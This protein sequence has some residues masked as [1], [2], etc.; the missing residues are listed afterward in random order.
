MGRQI[1]RRLILAAAVALTALP[2]SAQKDTEQK[3]SLVRLMKGS[4]I[5]LIE[6]YG[7]KYRKAIDATFLHNNTYLICDTALWNVDSK[8]IN[9]WGNVKLMQEETVLTSD[10]LDYD[11][12]E[13][14]AKFRG[15]VVQLQNKQ[16]NI[17]RTNNLDYNTKDSVAFFRDGASMKDK[18]GQVIESVVG[19]YD[20]KTRMFEFRD[21]VNMYTD[22]VFIRS[23]RL[24]Y[25]GNTNKVD[26]FSPVDFWK[27][28]NMLSA[29]RGWYDRNEDI[30]F[31]RDNVHGMSKDQETWSDTLFV[32]KKLRDIKM[33]GHVEIHDTTRSVSGVSNYLYYSDSLSR[34]TMRRD[35]A[36]TM[37]T[38]DKAKNR[39]DTLYAGADTLV[40]YSRMKFQIPEEVFKDARTRLDDMQ[41]DPVSEYRKKAA[42]AA[43]KAK[44]DAEAKEAENNPASR[45]L[46]NAAKTA[47]STARTSAPEES[48]ASAPEESTASAPEEPAVTAA[49]A[50]T[51]KSPSD[52]LRTGSD[53]LRAGRDSLLAG[54]DTLRAGRDSLL[55]GSDSLRTGADTLQVPDSSK[56]N[57]MLGVGNVRI[58]RRDMQIVCDS[59]VF[60]ELDSIARFY[61]DPIV[62]NE[63]NRQYTSDSLFVLI[64]GNAID[65]ASLM[66]NAFII[67]RED[68][69]RFDQIRSTEVM[70]YFDTTSALRRFDAMGGASALFYL[71]ENE[72]LSTVNKVE[73]KMLSAILKDGTIDKVYY[74]DAP[75]NDA[76]PVAQMKDN[77]H[78]MKGFEWRD[79]LRPKGPEDITT[80][81][82]RPSERS[83]Y[84]AHPKAAFKFTDK[85]FPGYM[86]SVYRAIEQSRLRKEMKREPAGDMTEMEVADSAAL[87][88]PDVT[89]SLQTETL[90]QKAV[91]DSLSARADSIARSDSLD[92]AAAEI[93]G[94]AASDVAP[95]R[96]EL[97]EEARKL[98]IARRDARWAELDARDAAKA[99]AKEQKKLEKQRARTKKALLR[100]MK[101][102]AKD[103]AK[104]RKY[105]ERYTRKK[106]REEERAAARQKKEAK[107]DTTNEQQQ[108]EPS[109]ERTPEATSWGDIPAPVESEQQTP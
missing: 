90:K 12:D 98:A 4:S 16:N 82:V 6:K 89:D 46:A 79:Q 72:T 17:L 3:D 22:S 24:V 80:L 108:S 64:R 55:A 42:E 60:S 20:S 69:L 47:E 43:A 8:L 85:Y 93:S 18:D 100:Q 54:S 38:E 77:E 33:L 50:D 40:Y 34:V 67:T 109:G 97:R 94:E 96:K 1:C 101:Q 29:K 78:F 35:A 37:A 7:V 84:D 52:T 81:K 26:F 88:A 104:L 56:V 87:A 48:A 99:A 107:P 66:S 105:V 95:T 83:A 73:S 53:T 13:N 23:K 11:V 25:Y 74:F 91:R 57:F 14:M 10:Q 9:C 75:K 65:R 51:L 76:Y 102:D 49:S 44:A 58:F 62:W 39:V 63:G 59:V 61:K 2:L 5:E 71:E 21:N 41:F 15:G 31:F 27:E 106:A 30:F 36:L 70:A 86:A 92:A 32:Y 45:A 68:S 103:E 28:D 19:N